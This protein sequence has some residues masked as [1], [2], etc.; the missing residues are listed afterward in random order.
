MKRKAGNSNK[1]KRAKAAVSKLHEAIKKRDYDLFQKALKEEGCDVNER[2]KDLIPPL[3]RAVQKSQMQMMKDLIKAGADVNIQCAA[4]KGSQLSSIEGVT[5]LHYAVK[6]NLAD[7]VEHLLQNGANPNIQDAKG[8]T[9]LHLLSLTRKKNYIKIATALLEH[10]ASP[11]ITNKDGKTPLQMIEQMDKGERVVELS[12]IREL[13]KKSI[14]SEQEPIKTFVSKLHEAIETKDDALFDEALGEEGCDVNKVDEY[15]RTPLY[16]AVQQNVNK[17]IDRLI[18]AGADVNFQT[19]DLD[20]KGHAVKCRTALHC[21][22]QQ[23]KEK[24]VVKLLEAKAEP[25]IAD[26][27][28]NTATHFIN[29][30][31]ANAEKITEH[32]LLAGANH[33]IVNR[34]GMLPIQVI[35]KSQNLRKKC[36]INSIA[37]LFH[38]YAVPEMDQ[39]DL[40]NFLHNAI[41]R[42]DLDAVQRLLQSVTAADQ[43]S[44]SLFFAVKHGRERLVKLFIESKA[45][46]NYR[47]PNDQYITPLHDAAKRNDQSIARLLLESKAL[48]NIPDVLGNTPLQCVTKPAYYATTLLLMAG[49]D[50]FIPNVSGDYSKTYKYIEHEWGIVKECVS[51]DNY[52]SLKGK[53]THWGNEDINIRCNLLR[54]FV[55]ESVMKD[56]SAYNSNTLDALTCATRLAWIDTTEIVFD[57]KGIMS[58]PQIGK[59]LRDIT[60]KIEALYKPQLQLQ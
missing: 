31:F 33:K 50:P 23:A 45:D 41:L 16:R 40:V 38:A 27:E 17:M 24:A 18:K 14:V 28:G 25:N 34:Y 56:V 7:Y 13:F 44:K 5:A 53:L 39:S 32:L 3:Y 10:G 43:M 48:P 11:D 36:S 29:I 52:T 19:P 58:I 54:K 8:N 12:K 4:G 20:T 22:V 59:I 60:N 1:S 6:E 2:D 37:G 46:V 57:E 21:A 30:S 26:A 15:G 42:D 35:G 47:S 49:A 51:K 55:Y 9:A